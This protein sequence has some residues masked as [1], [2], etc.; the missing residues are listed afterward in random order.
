MRRKG[1]ICA[2]Y[3]RKSCV[4]VENRYTNIRQKINHGCRKA[5]MLEKNVEI[6][7]MWGAW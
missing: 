7:M 3:G 2:D 5:I 1:L 4:R 6:G